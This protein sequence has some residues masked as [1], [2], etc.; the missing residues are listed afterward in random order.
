MGETPTEMPVTDLCL[1]HEVTAGET[2]QI[3]LVT[4]GPAESAR[5]AV[6]ELAFTDSTGSRL[7]VPDW[8][9]HSSLFGEYLYLRAKQ[10]QP[11]RTTL[12]ITAPETAQCLR[13]TGHSWSD[14]TGLQ[15]LSSPRVTR[16][17]D[18]VRAVNEPIGGEVT[19]G[20]A[21]A[22]VQARHH[23]PFDVETVQI[24]IPVQGNLRPAQQTLQLRFYAEDGAALSVREGNDRVPTIVN[25]MVE[26]HTSSWRAQ[27]EDITVPAGAA[28][29]RLTGPAPGPDRNP[30]TLTRLPGLLWKRPVENS[31][32]D[33]SDPAPG[34]SPAES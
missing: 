30:V 6:L 10:D 26:T 19:T 8:P 18:V 33:D 15:L 14:Y 17:D 25:I 9:H 29:L 23:V 34:P 21:L 3:D 12:L 20:I 4:L 31:V 32:D 16:L 1:D 7:A 24:D 22:A 28:T 11:R 5:A 13:L 27:S 2:L